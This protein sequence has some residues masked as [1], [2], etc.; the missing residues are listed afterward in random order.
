[1]ALIKSPKVSFLPMP[2]AELLLV[3]IRILIVVGRVLL[4]HDFEFALGLAPMTEW[5]NS[6]G[7]FISA[8]SLPTEVAAFGEAA[9]TSP[10]WPGK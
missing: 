6:Y 3:L 2:F 4:T 5:V 10:G 1:V 9:M 8:H 7:A